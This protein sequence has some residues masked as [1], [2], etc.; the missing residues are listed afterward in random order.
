MRL[1]IVDDSDV[2]RRMLR[3]VLGELP[4][5]A[6]VGEATSGEEALPRI[7]EARPDV[8]VM[9]WQMPGID[10]V[11]ATRRVLAE[12]PHVRVVGFTSSGEPGIHQAFLDAGAAAVFAKEQAFA[13]R[14]W[15]GALVAG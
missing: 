9:D 6:F 13:L 15:L 8:V 1:F 3:L 11:E 12:Y 5:L 4:G 14:D 2:A 10:G 7:G